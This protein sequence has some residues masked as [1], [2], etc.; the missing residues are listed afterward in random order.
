LGNVFLGHL[1]ATSAPLLSEFLSFLRLSL[2]DVAEVVE[3]TARSAKDNLRETDREVQ[4]GQRDSLGRTKSEVKGQ[5]VPEN[6]DPNDPKVKFEK[7]MDSA[8]Y[9]GSSVIGAAQEVKSTAIEYKDK[10]QARVLDA[11]DGVSIRFVS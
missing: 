9:A 11:F 3:G 2:S 6:V 1:S 5:D 4:E 7:G 10:S 8:K